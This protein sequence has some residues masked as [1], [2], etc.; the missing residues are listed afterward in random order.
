MLSCHWYIIWSILKNPKNIS[1][2]R[3][4]GCRRETCRRASP[5]ENVQIIQQDMRGRGQSCKNWRNKIIWF[6]TVI[7]PHNWCQTQ[8]LHPKRRARFFQI[9]NK[10]SSG[11]KTYL[12]CFP[13]SL[14]WYTMIYVPFRK[15]FVV[16]VLPLSP[17]ALTSSLSSLPWIQCLLYQLGTL[18]NK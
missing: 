12:G 8:I 3:F 11:G 2:R 7:S 9:C 14:P 4:Q 10:Y 6:V 15:L 17:I 18:N 13:V 5:P 1:K 16:A